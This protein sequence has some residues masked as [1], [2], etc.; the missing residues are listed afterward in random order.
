M[1][2]CYC[3]NLWHDLLCKLYSN[4]YEISDHLFFNYPVF[5]TIRKKLPQLSP[6]IAILWV[7]A[8][9]AE[10]LHFHKN[11]SELPVQR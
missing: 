7:S 8:T 3:T 6:T 1:M 5:A 9:A 2:P 10:D 4:P 11:G